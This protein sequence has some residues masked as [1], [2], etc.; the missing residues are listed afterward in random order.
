MLSVK[1]VL[2]LHHAHMVPDAQLIRRLLQGGGHLK[3]RHSGPLQRCILLAGAVHAD[4]AVGDDHITGLHIQI[5]AAGGAHANEGICAAHFQLLHG[6]G[7]G[8]AADAG[9]GHRYRYAQKLS[10]I[11]HIFPVIRN[12]LRI[13]EVGCDLRTALRISRQNHIFSHSSRLHIDMVETGGF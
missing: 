4:A 2:A 11:G 13:I 5:H 1:S 7:G 8:G 3:V 9:G 6:N 12:Q 10:G